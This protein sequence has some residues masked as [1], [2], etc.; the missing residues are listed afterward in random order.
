ML[1]RCVGYG[2]FPVFNNQGSYTPL[3]ASEIP[4]EPAP[5]FPNG[6]VQT[7]D[8]GLVYKNGYVVLTL[9]ASSGTASYFEVNYSGSTASATSRLLWSETLAAAS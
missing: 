2:A 9:G 1:G 5:S 6:Y 7:E 4:L 3:P 8:D